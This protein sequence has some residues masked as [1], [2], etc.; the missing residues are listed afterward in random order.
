[1]L[2]KSK[3]NK[4][5]KMKLRSRNKSRKVK[6]GTIYKNSVRKLSSVVRAAPVDS[7]TP[8]VPEESVMSDVPEESVMSDVPEESV[9]NNAPA[10]V[11]NNTVA[12]SVKKY[13]S[14]RKRDTP[15]KNEAEIVKFMEKEKRNQIKFME[16]EKKMNEW[17]NIAD[18]QFNKK[19][20]QEYRNFIKHSV[21]DSDIEQDWVDNNLQIIIDFMGVSELWE[22]LIPN[23]DLR[24][25]GRNSSNIPISIKPVAIYSGSHWTSRKAGDSYWFDPYKEYQINGS[26]QFCQ[27]YSLMYLLNALPSPITEYDISFMKFYEY[28]DKAINFIYATK[29]S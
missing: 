4:K 18:K 13:I 8:T 16:K 21:S 6:G 19:E 23:I 24:T 5:N 10:S 12:N 14:L 25:E 11:F 20:Y 27:T 22:I 29:R 28:T 15:K 3:K 7:V 9:V 1:M 17:K 2:K 26:N